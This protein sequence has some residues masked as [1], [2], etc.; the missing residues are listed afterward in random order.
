MF[1]KLI[2][3]AVIEEGSKVFFLFLNILEP[4]LKFSIPFF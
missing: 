3:N 4:P 1:Q 2:E